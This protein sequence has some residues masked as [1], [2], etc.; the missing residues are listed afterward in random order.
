VQPDSGAVVTGL[1][2]EAV[3]QFDEVIDEMP[4]AGAG[5]AGSLSRQVLLSPVS[6]G[7]RVQWHR[8]SISVKPR[9]GWKAGRVYRLELL[10]GI[11][12]LRRNKLDTGKVVLFSTG[13]AIGRARIGG[14]ALGWAEQRVIPRALIEAVPLPDSAGYLTLSDSGGQFNLEGLAPG[15]YIVYATMD[16]NADRRR[17]ARESYDSTLVTLDS[18]SN[19]ALYTFV[20]DTVG[21][22]LR[23]ATFVDSL[24]VRLDFTQALDPQTPLDSAHLRVLELPDSTPVPVKDVTSQRLYDSLTAAARRAADTTKRDTTARDSTPPR[25]AVQPQQPTVDTSLV[26]RLLSL[27]PI[28]TDR[29]VVTMA[30]ALKAETRYVFQVTGATNLIG[31]TAD[32]QVVLLA[33]KPEPPDTTRR[34]PRTRP[35]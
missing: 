32:G 13:P 27:R 23:S 6:G 1:D 3:I 8:S 16:E 10:P 4:G 17:G 28:P 12:D 31:R 2:D 18:S 29:V 15:R 7:V 26:R 9:E 20:H 21:P 25:A 24:T 5:G 14:I 33:P 11:L 22:R 34:A 30:R 19:V 35:P